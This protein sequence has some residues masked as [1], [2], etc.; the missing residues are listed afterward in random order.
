MEPADREGYQRFMATTKAIFPERALSNWPTSRSSPSATCSRRPDL[1][2][3]AVAQNRLQL[4]LA[5][6]RKRI[7]APLLLLPPLLIGGNPFDTTS[8]YA[9][10]HYLEREWGVHYVM[11]GTGA[12]VQALA[13]LIEE[14]GG[15]FHLNSEVAEILVDGRQAPRHGIRLADGTIH[16]ADHVI[17]NADVAFTYTHLIPAKIAASATQTPATT[18]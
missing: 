9:M 15:R 13:R 2:A 3:P 5:V 6:H 10:I 14:L 18:S 17:S 11:G 12:L 4:R 16:N 8:I 7:P 1:I